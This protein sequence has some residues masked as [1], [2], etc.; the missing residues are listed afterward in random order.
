MTTV[1]LVDWSQ[2]C[3][4]S[5]TAFG[6]DF[7]KGKDRLKQ[8]NIMRH[9]V[10]NTIIG[11]KKKFGRDTKVVIACDGRN[12][13]RKEVFPYYK[14]HRKANREESKTDWDSIF[15]TANKL[16]QEFTGVFPY[17]FVLYDRAE[18]DDVVGVLC[19]YWQDNELDQVGA[20]GDQPVDVIIKSSD[21]DF[22]QL[23]KYPNVKQW[24]SIRKKYITKKET[25]FLLEKILTG[26]TGDGIPNVKMPA[27]F[28]V[29]GV[30]RQKS[31]TAKI[32]SDA[33]AQI[34]DGKLVYFG[35]KEMD[36]GYR[37]NR[38]LIDFDYIPQDVSD[39]IIAAYNEQ[40]IV[41][42]KQGIFNYLISHRCKNLIERIQEF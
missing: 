18:A 33:V 28:L 9:S 2:V 42:N 1:L 25:H 10:L 14:S 22:G 29:N 30:G 41:N 38:Q 26:D 34:N 40:T 37:R 19:K 39:A 21:G 23:H 31:I 20:F 24:D 36:E 4:A 32:K 11:D 3:I 15:Q 35:D 5:A 7:D 8:E 16:R 27:D 12:Y 13:W 17:K 6:S